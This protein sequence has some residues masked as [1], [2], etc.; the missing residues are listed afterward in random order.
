MPGWLLHQY[1]YSPGSSKVWVKP[2]ELRMVPEP[3]PSLKFTVWGAEP[4]FTQVTESPAEI[5]SDSGS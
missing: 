2:R 5:V 3:S 4:S 1:S